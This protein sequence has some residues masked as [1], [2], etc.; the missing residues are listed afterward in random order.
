MSAEISMEYDSE[1]N[2][3]LFII[4]EGSEKRTLKFDFDGLLQLIQKSNSIAR[5]MKQSRIICIGDH[6]GG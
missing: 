1:K 5:Q 4:H 2:Q 3:A 6:R